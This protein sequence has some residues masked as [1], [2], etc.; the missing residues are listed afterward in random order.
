MRFEIDIVPMGAVRMTR[1]SK[2]VDNDAK[3]YLDYKS[4]VYFEVLKQLNGVYNPINTAVGVEVLFKMPIPESWSKREKEKAP[5]TLHTKKP[6]IDNMVK[7]LFDA[8]NGLIWVDDNRVSEVTVRKVY[9]NNPGIEFTVETI[10]G[11]SYGQVES[12]ERGRTIEDR[13]RP[14]KPN[15]V[16]VR[17]RKQRIEKEKR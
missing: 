6:D 5:G 8:L 7:G 16:H 4:A 13:N 15:R 17:E 2:F 14:S 1:K 3:G 12:N 10:G 11:L 9:S